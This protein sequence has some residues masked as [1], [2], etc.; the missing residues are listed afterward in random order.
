VVLPRPARRA[1]VS[2]FIVLHFGGMATAAL[3]APPTPWLASQLWSRFYRPY[4]EFMYLNNAYHFYSPEPGP[5]SLLWFCVE[6]VDG[7]G[8]HFTHWKKVPDIDEYGRHSYPL[9]LVYQRRLSLSQFTEPSDRS[10]YTLPGPDGVP[11]LLRIQAR[12]RMYAPPDPGD[13][14]PVP[15]VGPRPLPPEMLGKEDPV[16]PE[17]VPAER[18]V[19]FHPEIPRE[20]QFQPPTVFAKKLAE[21]YARYTTA[22]P[23][24][25]HPDWRAVKV[26]IYR[27][28]HVIPPA[29]HIGEGADPCSPVYYLPYY[30]GEYDRDGKL[31]R[32]AENDPLLYWLVPALPEP[33]PGFPSPSYIRS[34][35]RR[36]A[37]ETAWVWNLHT[38]E[39]VVP[40]GE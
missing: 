9:G 18:K 4:L 6:Y 36:H 39:W 12:R 38:L 17:Q 28:V 34:Y 5:P 29:K 32:E 1:V 3:S 21:S 24:P 31:T 15:V 7:G 10:A 23:H 11:R 37:G 19:P 27:V 30:L 2:V 25:E 20:N 33:R 13:T 35:V 16:L 22:L 14:P 26:K 8:R 40:P